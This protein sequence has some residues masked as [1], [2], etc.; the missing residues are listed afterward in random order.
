MLFTQINMYSGSERVE[1]CQGE[2]LFTIE[3]NVWFYSV[4]CE[5]VIFQHKQFD[6]RSEI[7]LVGLHIYKDIYDKQ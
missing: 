3:G 7:F 6:V 5:K 1:T 2:N 4:V